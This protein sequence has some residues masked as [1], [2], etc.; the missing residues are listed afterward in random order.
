MKIFLKVFVGIVIL[1]L[2]IKILSVVFLEP[3]A[4]AKMEAALNEKGS[5]YRFEINRVRIF[6]LGGGMDIRDIEI[7]M[8][9]N[10][11][12]KKELIGQIEF[13]KFRGIKVAQAIFR[14]DIV[15]KKI[16]VGE[17]KL[18]VE[19][20]FPRDTLNKV[21]LPYNLKVGSIQFK[22]INL[23][24]K[25]AAS[26]AAYS[27]KDGTLKLYDIR[28]K[29]Q[30]ALS[31]GIIKHI[32]FN[33]DELFLVSAD[34]MYSFCASGLKY[35]AGLNTFFI[36]SFFVQPNYNDYDFVSRCPFQ[37]DRV[38]AAINRIYIHDFNLVEY[39]SSGN[40]ISNYLEVGVMDMKIFRDKRKEFKHVNKPSL[41]EIIGSYP[42]ILK[43]DSIALS[44]GRVTYKEHAEKANEAGYVSFHK[45]T[46]RIYNMTNDPLYIRENPLFS[47]K[48]NGLLMGYGFIS[49]SLEAKLVDS[50]HVF[51]LTGTLSSMEAN[52]LNPILEKNAFVSVKTGKIGKMSF[53]LTANSKR[54]DGKMTLLY[55]ELDIAV[56]NNVTDETTAFKERVISFIANKMIMNSNPLQGE[57]A[58][59]GIISFERDSEK[60][61]V[62]YSFK[63]V[64]SGVTSS[65]EKNP[66]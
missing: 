61:F 22:R 14:K 56:I 9:M 38:E 29:K 24:V 18:N 57:K 8:G 55:H 36:D 3:L 63:S 58:R 10:S 5:N 16:L 34:S 42:G 11:S 33:A 51:W 48:S 41:Q 1:V 40:F 50:S 46:A 21:L 4:K 53:N 66:K 17:S 7:F 12:G 13:L 25:N 27:L 23:I 31:P 54:A 59:E 52:E 65:L 64:L 39:L 30:D 26:K 47:L 44:E 60:S 49:V 35:P 45:I 37:T 15:V 43:I 28:G 62:N 32:E 6:M 19:F 2:L 20:I